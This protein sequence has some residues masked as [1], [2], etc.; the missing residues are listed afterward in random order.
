MSAVL[1]PRLEIRN[2]V[3]A[4]SRLTPHKSE[5]LVLLFALL[6]FLPSLIAPPHLMD[7]EDAARAQ[8]SR[9]MLQSGDWITPRLDGIRYFEKPPL[10]YWI[11]AASMA[12]FGDNETAARIPTCLIGIVLNQ[13]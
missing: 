12:V 6:V 3:A 5:L 13:E 1:A 8:I 7:D 4:K 11:V 10:M 2:E 9:N